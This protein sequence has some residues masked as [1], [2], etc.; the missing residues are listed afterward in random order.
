MH[1]GLREQRASPTG[2]SECPEVQMGSI[3][4]EVLC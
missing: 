1:W 4:S 3:G 2:S